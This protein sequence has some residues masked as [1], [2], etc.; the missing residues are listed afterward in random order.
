MLTSFGFNRVEVSA[1]LGV[2]AGRMIVPGSER[3]THYWMQ[4][5]T[6]FDE[7]IGVDFSAI[8]LDRIYRVSDLLIKK[9]PVIE[10]HLCR[11]QDE[12]F[13]RRKDYS[14]RSDQHIF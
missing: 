5:A 14:L 13:A 6:A 2:I 10:E 11:K 4:N 8:S 9:K 7:L 3:A 12:L 1:A